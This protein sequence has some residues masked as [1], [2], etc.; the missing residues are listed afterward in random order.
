MKCADVF[1]Y[2]NRKSGQELICIVQEYC[3]KGDLKT[4]ID[5]QRAQN[6]SI[7]ESRIRKWVI[8]ILMALDNIHERRIVHR[9]LKPSNLFL[10][11]KN[12]DIKV[13]DFGIARMMSGQTISH[14]NIGTLCY[15]APE[16]VLNEQY[17]CSSDIWSLGCVI[18][19]LSTFHMAFNS[20][21][22]KN[23]TDKITKQ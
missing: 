4:H 19:E 1:S 15:S 22:E 5:M 8:E 16:V 2:E 23:L 17:D 21:T 11:G 18:F 7:R 6:T 12:L 9:D 10:K 3:D 13:G 20:N 14:S